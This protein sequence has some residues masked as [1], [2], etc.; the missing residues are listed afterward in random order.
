VSAKRSRAVSPP[1]VIANWKATG[2]GWQTRL[3]EVLEK[4]TSVSKVH[5]QEFT[6]PVRYR[7]GRAA[8]FGRPSG[9]SSP[10]FALLA[11]NRPLRCTENPRVDGSIYSDRPWPILTL[12]AA[13]LS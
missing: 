9:N 2:P 6:A 8:R 7:L 4:S 10:V 13:A 1:E 12:R 5:N 11:P 3:A